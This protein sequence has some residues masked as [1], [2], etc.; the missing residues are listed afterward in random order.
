MK[1]HFVIKYEPGILEAITFDEN[2]NET[3]RSSLKSANESEIHLSVVPEEKEIPEGEI[4]F[5]NIRIQDASGIVESNADAKV[6]VRVEGGD[7]LAFGS[8]NPRTEEMFGD[9][10]YTTYFGQSM[11]V[12]KSTKKGIIRVM[13]EDVTGRK[14]ACEINVV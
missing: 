12:V 1:A 10:S 5:V 7:L 6:N 3:G 14:G 11:A 4:C 8:A 13:A 2:G 9:G